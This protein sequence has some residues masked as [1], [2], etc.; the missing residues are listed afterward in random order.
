MLRSPTSPAARTVGVLLVALVGGLAATLVANGNPPNMGVCG[1]CFLRDAGAALGLVAPG[2]KGGPACIRPELVGLVLG[3]TGLAVARGRFVARSGSHAASRLTLGF[4]MGV[5]ALVFLGCPF[6][7]L[8]RLGGGDGSALAGLAGFVPGVL[9]AR[10]FERAGYTVGRTS[11]A[12]AAVGLQGPVAFVL[13]LVAAEAAFLAGPRPTGGGPPLR[14]PAALALGV[15]LAAGALLSATGFCV[16]S[17]ARAVL[18]RPRGMLLAAGALVAA[19]AATALATGTFS[20]G[21][22]GSPLAHGDVLWS[23]L[24]MALVGLAGAFAG[25]C[26]VRQLVLTGEGNGD[27]FVTTVGILLGTVVAHGVGAA[28]SPAGTTPPGRVLVVLGLVWALLHGALVTAS[29]RRSAAAGAAP[30]PA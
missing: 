27:G 25:G 17:A 7:M 28:S 8:Q 18:D 23:A 6:R 2:P 26:P 15:G 9:L 20:F 12:P 14:A 4:F 13:L 22:R 5:G 3:A 24:A 16:V 10:R 29:A 21:F 19:Y 11:P 30:G 1:A